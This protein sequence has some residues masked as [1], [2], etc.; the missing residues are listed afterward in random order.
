MHKA[1]YWGRLRVVKYLVRH[2]AN[3]NAKD[4]NGRTPLHLA[5]GGRHFEVVKYLV[6]H[7]ADVNAKDKDGN[8]SLHKA[9]IMNELEVVKYLVKHGANLNAKNK[10]GKTPL[11]LAYEES[12]NPKVAKYLV[13]VYISRGM[14]DVKFSNGLTLLHFAAYG[15]DVKQ[16]RYLIEKKGFD[17]NVKDGKGGLPLHYAALGGSLDVV[18]YL[19]EE[20]G[21]DVGVVDSAN[22]TP[23]HYATI[24]ARR[25]NLGFWKSVAMASGFENLGMEKTVKSFAED[26]I[27]Y[28]GIISNFIEVMNYLI[29]HG[30]DVNA[31]DANGETPLHLITELKYGADLDVVKFLVEHGADVNARNNDG[32]TPCDVAKDD[33]IRKVMGCR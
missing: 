28:T 22:S 1:A 2:G 13:G 19:V 24:G 15:G 33:D 25:A 11:D 32:W 16:V 7:G 21:V 18:K 23:L 3:V 27:Y 8:T 12:Y 14:T 4:K 29:E 6:K 31:R 9:V 26:A 30:A 10:E 17:I 20:R 5:I